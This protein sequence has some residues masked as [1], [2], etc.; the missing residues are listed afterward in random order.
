MIRLYLALTIAALG[1]FLAVLALMDGHWLAAISIALSGIYCGF[2]VLF[3]IRNALSN[4]M[5][6]MAAAFIGLFGLIAVFLDHRALDIELQDAH[7]AAFTSFANNYSYCRPMSATWKIFANGMRACAMQGSSDQLSLSSDVTKGIY[8]GPTLS[9]VDSA[10]TATI[11][12]PI[13]NCASAF[14]AAFAA[15]PEAFYSLS[16]SQK[17]ALLKALQ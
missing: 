6:D 9:M 2:R 4:P 3:G 13:D 17:S 7:A 10:Y 8:F 12:A 11:E 1:L 16:E 5:F 15:C 14:K